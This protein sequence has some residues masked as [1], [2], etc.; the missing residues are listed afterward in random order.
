MSTTEIEGLE[1]GASPTFLQHVFKFD[2]AS[3]KEMMN[4]GQ[5]TLVG[6]VPIVLLNKLILKYVPEADEEKGSVELLAEVAIQVIIMFLGILI[7]DRIVTFVPTYS[8]V[9]YE[10]VQV[11]SVILAVLLI[12][13]SLQTKLGEKITIL[14]DRAAVLITGKKEGMENNESEQGTQ[15]EHA[16]PTTHLVNANTPGTTMQPLS[17]MPANPTQPSLVSAPG[18]GTPINSVGS[19]AIREA[20]RAQKAPDTFVPVAANEGGAFEKCLGTSF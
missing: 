9:K 19:Q 10:K 1:G 18:R 6:L 15:S 5:Y 4:V 14:Y 7:I 12:T 13:L 17:Q 16:G 20:P 2:E 11:T 8:G 3:K